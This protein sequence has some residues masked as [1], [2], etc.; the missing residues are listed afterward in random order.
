MKYVLVY[1][2]YNT[3]GCRKCKKGDNIVS[4]KVTPDGYSDIVLRLSDV[5]LKSYLI[6]NLF[7]RKDTCML[8]RTMEMLLF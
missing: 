8:L 3:H 2:Q 5:Q 4:K 7:E 1:S 6:D